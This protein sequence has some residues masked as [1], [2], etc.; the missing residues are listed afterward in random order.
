MMDG[1]PATAL[2]SAAVDMANFSVKPSLMLIP[3]EPF[4]N[5]S[6]RGFAAN[7]AS[8][9]AA[10]QPSVCKQVYTNP[11]ASPL[12][13]KNTRIATRIMSKTIKPPFSD[14]HVCSRIFLQSALRGSG[15]RS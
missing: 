4:S 2:S 13:A 8:T 12:A 11:F 9:I 10:I 14:S 3:S 1:M 15:K 6:A 5:M 7:Q